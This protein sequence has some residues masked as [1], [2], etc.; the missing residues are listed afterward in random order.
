MVIGWNGETLPA[1][2]LESEIEVVAA[3]G[4]GGI[5][6]F[7]PKLA[8]Y[9]EHR[10]PR[11]LSR[12]LR[13]TGLA[14]LTMNGIEDFNLRSPE[15]FATVS[16]E[17]RWLSE[18][19]QQI[20]CPGIVVVPSP[21]PEGI[22]WDVV[23]AQTAA[24]LQDLADLAA[25]FGVTLGLEFLAPAECSVR[26]LEQAW[27]ILGIADR[28]NLCVVFDTYHFFVGGSSWKSLEDVPVDRLLLVHIN[29]VEDLPFAELTDGHRML[30]GEGVLTLDRILST[31]GKR[32]YDGAYSLE[33]MRPEYMNREPQE[34]ARA[35]LQ[36]TREAL[37]AAGLV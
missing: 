31:L 32:G 24:A 8:P 3:A 1:L 35:G 13:E 30:P 7:I 19:S 9:L 17:C 6:L 14:P 16:D 20:G 12:R 21:N 37:Q 5:E 11:D 4:Y 34:Y 29:D 15:E 28:D 25:P 2:H 10:T 22:G 36:T 27:E 33:V 23:R 18:L 26:T